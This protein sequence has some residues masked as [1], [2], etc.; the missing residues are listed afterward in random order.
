MTDNERPTG[1]YERP[2]RRDI[3]AQ[4]LAELVLELSLAFW[5]QLEKCV[6]VPTVE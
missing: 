6:G 1:G 2:S 5:T 3:A 4:K